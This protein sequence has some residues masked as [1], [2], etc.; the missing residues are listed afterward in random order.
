MTGFARSLVVLLIA[1][2]MAGTLVMS[3]EVV[4]AEASVTMEAMPM[5]S[6]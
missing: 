2:F 3:G 5:A 6:V 4:R 1:V